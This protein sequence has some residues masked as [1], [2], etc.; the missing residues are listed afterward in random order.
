MTNDEYKA[1][2]EQSSKSMT[3]E[4]MH[5]KETTEIKTGMA[6]LNRHMM[7][8]FYA[9]IG[10]AGV[11]F[12]M[13]FV[14][15]PFIT[16]LMAYITLFASIFLALMT[17]HS[18]KKLIWIGRIQR[19]LFISFMMCSGYGRAIIFQSGRMLAPTWWGPMVDVFF[20]AIAL[21]Y[22][23]HTIQGMEKDAKGNDRKLD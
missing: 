2:I 22:L 18:W 20:I 12:G 8:M 11:G 21:C 15:T 10:L 1:R 6:L 23:A 4:Q 5:Y 16:D 7:K 17:W 13:K 19:I 3:Q 9:L 14:G